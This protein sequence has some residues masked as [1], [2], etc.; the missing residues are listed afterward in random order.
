M[1]A[2]LPRRPLGEASR[3]YLRP[4]VGLRPPGPQ[5][6]LGEQRGGPRRGRPWMTQVRVRRRGCGGGGGPLPTLPVCG[7][8]L[9]SLV[10]AGP[11]AV[12]H[13]GTQA[14]CTP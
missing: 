7:L 1:L 13:V 9:S 10:S 3:G 4:E 12:A 5:A 6:S 11:Q 2:G 14:S 8:P